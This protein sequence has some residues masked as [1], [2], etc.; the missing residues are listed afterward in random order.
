MVDVIHPRHTA[1]IVAEAQLVLVDGHGH[2]SIEALVTV[3]PAVHPISSRHEGE[4]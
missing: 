1:S 4:P 2:F 3:D